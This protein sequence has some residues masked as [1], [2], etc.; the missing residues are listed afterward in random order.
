[1]TTSEKYSN[2]KLVVPPR[3]LDELISEL[4]DIFSQDRVNIEYVQALLESYKSNP[5]DWKRFAKFDQHRYT[6]NL[7]DEGNGKFN[8]M[9][10]CWGENH[11]SSIH[12]HANSHCFVKVLNGALK[13]TRFAWPNES[14]PENEM[15]RIGEETFEKDGVTYMCDEIGLHRMENP[16]HTEGAVTM[17]LYSPPFM[18]CK[19][20]DERTGHANVAKMT[21][22]SKYGERTPFRVAKIEDTSPSTDIMPCCGSPPENN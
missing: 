7:I 17:H 9:M 11:G 21:F 18:E 12:D 19:M 14:E 1:M 10:L 3:N 15:R 16:S 22:W 5:K 8:L 2:E 20:F 13:E 4:R 6:R